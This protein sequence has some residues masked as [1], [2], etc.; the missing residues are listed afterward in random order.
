MKS[1]YIGQVDRPLI[2]KL[3]DAN[4]KEKVRKIEAEKP[5]EPT[6]QEKVKEVLGK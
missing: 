3:A 6:L 2:D 1:K 4:V 5:K